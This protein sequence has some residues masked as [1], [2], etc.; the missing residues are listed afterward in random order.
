[1]QTGKQRKTYLDFL[2]VLAA[3]LVLYNHTAGFHF[4]L[5]H[6]TSSR[7]ILCTILASSF[8]RINV[9]LFFM[10]S[11]ALLLGKDFSYKDLL[12]KRIP[13]FAAVLFAASMLLYTA[14]RFDH[15]DLLNAIATSVTCNVTGVYWFLFTYIG[16]LFILPFLRMIAERITWREVLL[17][18]ICR[19]VFTGIPTVLDHVSYLQGW[20]HAALPGYFSIP[21]AEVDFIFFPLT[22]YWLDRN[23]SGKTIQKWL[24]LLVIFI[25]GDLMISGGISYRWYTWDMASQTYLG[26]FSPLTAIS[27]FLIVKYIFELL[28][29]KI[30]GRL[31][32]KILTCISSLTLGIYLIDPFLKDHV[33]LFD[34]MEAWFGGA[35]HVLPLS[36]LY[37]IVSM[38]IGGII[39]WILKKLPVTG[40]YL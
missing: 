11:G 8:T 27:V 17:L 33:H 20:Y 23:L 14:E 3:F 5:D 7:V 29:P 39:T 1:M 15:F 28:Q 13:R 9:L 4:F 2:R 26:I 25:L 6:K 35:I 36:V 37:C 12:G 30:Q 34:K 24:P 21:F 31:P 18:V 10:I 38:A 19:T 40:K 22:G 32:E 16:F